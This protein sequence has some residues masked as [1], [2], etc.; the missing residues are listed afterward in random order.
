MTNA[1]RKGNDKDHT[2]QCDLVYTA[3][4]GH[5]ATPK[6]LANQLGLPPGRITARLSDLQK[7]GRA[8]PSKEAD[9]GTYYTAEVNPLRFEAHAKAYEKKMDV[10]AFVKAAKVLK[11]YLPDRVVTDLRITYQKLLSK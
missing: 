3:L 1:Q 6:Q 9:E 8:Y 2:S 7:Q 11:P 10:K 4:V 5:A